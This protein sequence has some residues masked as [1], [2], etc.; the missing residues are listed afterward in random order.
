MY[1]QRTHI[2]IYGLDHSDVLYMYMHPYA[3]MCCQRMSVYTVYIYSEVLER[4]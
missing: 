4:V 3:S 1:V 2:R